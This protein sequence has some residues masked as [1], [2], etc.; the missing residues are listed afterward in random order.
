MRKVIHAISFYTFSILT[1]PFKFMPLRWL[2]GISDIMYLTIYKIIGYRVDVVKKNLKNSFPQKTES[3]LLEIER[4]F[5]RHFCDLFV[6][7]F[8][9]LHANA[10]KAKR[11][12]SFKNLEQ[13]DRYYNENK[14]IVVAGG[15]YGNW[16]LYGLFGLFLKHQV[17]GAYKPLA[18]KYF[19]SFVNASRERFGALAVPMR[20]TPRTAMQFAREGKLFFLG[21][22]ADQTPAKGEIR[23]WTTFLNQDTPVFLG[24]EKI[25]KKLNQPVFFCNM[26]KLKRGFYE[27]E[28]ELLTDKPA[29]T[30]PY[31]ITEMHVRA[32]ERLINEAP[33]YWL[34]SH[35]RWKHSR[36]LTQTP[37]E[38]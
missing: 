25:A 2:Y 27:V 11:L 3:E 37:N 10:K 15:H 9:I 6:E 18:N 8:Y 19:E 22:I 14:S 38:Q 21:L 30:K 7:Q 5:Y 29:E 31:E 20:D 35:R 26:R 1:F 16:E 13:L 32:L 24:T 23:Y 12:C 36:N 33:E 17:F 4:K 34:W 28:L